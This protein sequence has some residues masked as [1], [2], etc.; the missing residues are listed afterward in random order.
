MAPSGRHGTAF[1]LT[2]IAWLLI[3]WGFLHIDF[4]LERYERSLHIVWL[5]RLGDIGSRLGAGVV[6]ATISGGMAL[7]AWFRGWPG[8]RETGIRA[9]LAQLLAGTLAEALKFLIGRPRPRMLHGND[10]Q[11]GPTLTRGLESFPSGHASIAFAVAAVFARRYPAYA[12]PVFALA[13]FVAA[14]RIIRGSHFPTDV[15]VGA[16]LGLTIGRLV[17]EPLRDW[18]R[19]VREAVLDLTPYLALVFCIAWTV[20]SPPL[21]QGGLA[22]AAGLVLIAGGAWAAFAGRPWAPSWT[23]PVVGAACIAGPPIVIAVAGLTMLG[24]WLRNARQAETRRAVA[25]RT[26]MIALAAAALYAVRGALPIVPI[27]P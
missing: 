26:V 18:A 1:L 27:Q 11:L 7:V 13:G 22:A 19:T 4:P 20:M 24:M 9:L 25:V 10:L 3:F 14:S 23:W 15:M 6:V 5:E 21:S 17:V 16:T 8:L 12:V 2:L